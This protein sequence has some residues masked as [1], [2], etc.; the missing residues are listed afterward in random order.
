MTHRLEISG[1]GCLTIRLAFANR[2]YFDC[3]VQFLCWVFWTTSWRIY[4]R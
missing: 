1:N 2:T 3:N 4:L